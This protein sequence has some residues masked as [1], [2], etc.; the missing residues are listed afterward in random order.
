MKP[1]AELT[2]A[3]LLEVYPELRSCIFDEFETS[4]SGAKGVA[5]LAERRA[6]T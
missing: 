5:A 2:R 1:L 4:V 6:K 3:E